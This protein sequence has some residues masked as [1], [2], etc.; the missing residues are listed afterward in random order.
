MRAEHIESTCEQSFCL[1]VPQA[2][3]IPR[4]QYNNVFSQEMQTV[5]DCGLSNLFSY[6]RCG[7]RSVASCEKIDGVRGTFSL[8]KPSLY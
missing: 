2:S 7:S 5:N 3:Y 6:V 8:L 4:P 1:F